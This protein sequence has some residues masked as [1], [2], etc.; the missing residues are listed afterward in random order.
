[1]KDAL[2][3]SEKIT[4][5]VMWIFGWSVAIYSHV[6]PHKD[7]FDRLVFELLRHFD[8]LLWILPLVAFL[9]IK[10]SK[11]SSAISRLVYAT[12]LIILVIG[13]IYLRL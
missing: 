2:S 8:L 4:I 7:K 6:A 9:W 1:M 13:S 5:G 3:Q 12:I 10:G 11:A